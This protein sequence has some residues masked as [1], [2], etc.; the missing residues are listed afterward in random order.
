M[1]YEE[2]NRSVPIIRKIID[3]YISN[4][5]PKNPVDGTSILF[6]E[7]QEI[8]DVDENLKKQCKQFAK[9]VI[10]EFDLARKF[11]SIIL[12]RRL[13]YGDCFIEVVDVP[14]EAEKVNFSKMNMVTDSLQLFSKKNELTINE[15][16]FELMKYLDIIVDSSINIGDNFEFTQLLKEERTIKNLD[17]LQVD[18]V[19]GK[20]IGRAHV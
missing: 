14:K 18:I 5:I 2:I 3:V 11:K 19:T 13:L 12:P 20:Q 15:T 7:T 9:D 8:A 1:A 4:I 17:N 10:N 6:R 16:E